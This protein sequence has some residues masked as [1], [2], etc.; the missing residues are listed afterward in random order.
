M[1]VVSFMQK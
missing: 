1:K